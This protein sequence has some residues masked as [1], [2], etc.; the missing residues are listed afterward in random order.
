MELS[1]FYISYGKNKKCYEVRKGYMAVH[2]NSVVMGNIKSKAKT[3]ENGIIVK[4]PEVKQMQERIWNKSTKNNHY[5]LNNLIKELSFKHLFSS[6]GH[7][8]HL[9]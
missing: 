2:V 4:Y 7:S 5:E 6:Q 9:L 8:H 3:I 1:Y